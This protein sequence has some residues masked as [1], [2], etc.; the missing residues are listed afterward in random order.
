MAR[1]ELMKDHINYVL[2]ELDGYAK[3]RDDASGA[4]VTWKYLHSIAPTKLFVP[5]LMLRQDLAIGYSHS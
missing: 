2:R 5:G 4:E 1:T 3:M